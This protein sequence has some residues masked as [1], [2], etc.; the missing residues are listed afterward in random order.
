[1]SEFENSFE[2]SNAEI[3]LEFH[4]DK[5]LTLTPRGLPP[6]CEYV[7]F[8]ERIIGV[9][10]QRFAKI[11]SFDVYYYD[12]SICPLKYIVSSNMCVNLGSAVGNSRCKTTHNAKS[13]N[14]ITNCD[15]ARRHRA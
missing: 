12:L 10:F 13:K 14:D 5:V 9:S 3:T 2:V 7:I 11:F 6:M 1:V 15:L 4:T 8:R